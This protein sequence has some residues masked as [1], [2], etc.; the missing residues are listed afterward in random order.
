MNDP[1][2]RPDPR[3][4][5]TDH[6]EH[7]GWPKT[8]QEQ[9]ELERRRGSQFPMEDANAL[10]PPYEGSLRRLDASWRKEFARLF[11][12]HPED[13]AHVKERWEKRLRKQ[14]I[15]LPT[16]LEDPVDYTTECR[17]RFLAYRERRRHTLP[18]VRE[19]LEAFGSDFGR[20]RTILD[21]HQAGC[22]TF[23]KI[24]RLHE[25]LMAEIANATPAQERATDGGS[26]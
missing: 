14:E 7:D 17:R 25:T 26:S 24:E 21:R 3:A 18:Y 10:E 9:V 12:G 19:L 5:L 16:H 22:A 23:S 1:T 11:R 6:H 20:I 15:P 8:Q 13:A 4:T 2:P